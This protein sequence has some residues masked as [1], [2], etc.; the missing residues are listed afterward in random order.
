MS[1]YVA[2]GRVEG[3]R[4][5]AIAWEDRS[6]EATL[7]AAAAAPDAAGDAALLLDAD[8]GSELSERW[9]RF[10]DQLSMTTF[11]LL[12]PESWR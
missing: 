5:R 3:G 6:R 8:R 11:F 7:T 2:I 9:S 1:G 4:V 10:R 12:D